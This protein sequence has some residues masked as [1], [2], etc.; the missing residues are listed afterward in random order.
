MEQYFSKILLFT[1]FLIKIGTW[2]QDTIHTTL[3]AAL[4]DAKMKWC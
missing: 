4:A 1:S 2:H 3:A